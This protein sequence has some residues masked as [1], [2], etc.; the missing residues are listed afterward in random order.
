MD[1]TRSGSTGEGYQ[2]SPF[3]GAATTLTGRLY[4]TG[5]WHYQST[6]V[7]FLRVFV[8]VT[9]GSATLTGRIVPAPVVL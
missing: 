9:G 2:T 5:S 7:P 8:W 4:N 6:K 1:P 3:T